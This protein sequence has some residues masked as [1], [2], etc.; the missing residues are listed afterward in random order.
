M[1]TELRNERG[2]SEERSPEAR[3]P[4]ARSPADRYRVEQVMTRPVRTLPPETTVLQA[5][6]CARAWSVHHLP[7]GQAGAV[8]GVLCTCDL[9]EAKLTEPL[10]EVI[11]RPPL[12]IDTRSSC[13]AAG[14]RMRQQLVNSLLVTDGA[15]VVGIVT[16]SDL[17]AL[18]ADEPLRETCC[19]CCG[20]TRHLTRDEHGQLLCAECRER[21]TAPELYD[22]GGG[23]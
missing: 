19:W 11:R 6:G 4:E 1:S 15:Q 23:F 5:L 13:R 9:R 7:V 3:S 17:A 8:L 20:E 22:T 12:T 16:R 2:L 18:S 21:A 14:E 10:R